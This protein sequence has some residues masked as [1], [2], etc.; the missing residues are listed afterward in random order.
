MS[1]GNVALQDVVID[2]RLV[3]VCG[4]GAL[5][6]NL[7]YKLPG[8]LILGLVKAGLAV[9]HDIGQHRLSMHQR[10]KFQAGDYGTKSWFSPTHML[11][12]SS[13]STS[14]RTLA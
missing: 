1:D 7:R 13:S 11:R 14:F 10:C 3:L 2:A 6:L 12:S 4:P 8:R 9:L 5:D